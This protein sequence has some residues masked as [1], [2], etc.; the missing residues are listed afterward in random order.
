MARARGELDAPEAVETRSRPASAARTRSLIAT[1]SVRW[2]GSKPIA[3]TSRSSRRESGARA[4]TEIGH[5][6]RDHVDPTRLDA[7]LPHRRDGAVERAGC[8]TDLEDRLGGRDE[9]VLAARHRR[10]PGVART[11]LEDELAAR[12]ADDAGHHPERRPARR[13]P[14]P[15]RRGARGTTREARRA[16]RARGSRCSRP[17]RPGRHDDR[18][19]PARST[20]SI[21]ATTPSAPSKPATL[22]HRCRGA[23]RPRRRAAPSSVRAGSR[24]IGLDREPGLPQPAGCELERL[25]LGRARVRSVRPAPA[26]DRVQLLEALEDP[27]AGSVER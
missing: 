3:A 5:A 15:A 27:H 19:A 7:D 24:R 20:A 2:S 23:I 10:R 14:A 26:A 21:A 8:V 11:S 13:A 17:P 12:V 16:R 1:G 4:S 9:R 6:T 22:R 18:P 25:V